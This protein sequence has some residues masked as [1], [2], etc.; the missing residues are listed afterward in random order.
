[1]NLFNTSQFAPF[2]D[3]SYGVSVIFLL[4]VSILTFTRYRRAIRRLA[5]AEA[6][7]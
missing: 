4:G 3:G 1:M 5:Q 7:K 2:I 6:A